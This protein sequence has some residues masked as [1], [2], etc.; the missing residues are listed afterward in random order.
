MSKILRGDEREI[1][2]LRKELSEESI[3]V[4]ICASLPRTL[5]IAEINL[6]L[7]CLAECLMLGHFLSPI[8]GKA[9][10]EFEGKSVESFGKFITGLPCFPLGELAEHEVP[11]RALHERADEGVPAEDEI[12]FPM[13]GDGTI[14]NVRRTIMD[15]HHFSNLA[16]TIMQQRSTVLA[17]FVLSPQKREQFFTQSASGK[18]VESRVN[19]FMGDLHGGCSIRFPERC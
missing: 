17:S 8:V 4:F 6:H 12:S 11:G 14:L 15:A 18:N 10:T 16:A 1:C 3:G 9:L 13:T 7:R 5:W 2:S 19:G